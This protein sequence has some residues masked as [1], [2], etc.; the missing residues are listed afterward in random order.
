MPSLIEKFAKVLM[1]TISPSNKAFLQISP[2]HVKQDLSERSLNQY[3]KKDLSQD[4]T[5]TKFGNEAEN[6]M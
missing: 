1:K 4:K 6:K 3:T 2:H 5:C